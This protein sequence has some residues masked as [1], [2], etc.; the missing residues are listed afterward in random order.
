MFSRESECKN[1]GAADWHSRHS[2]APDLISAQRLSVNNLADAQPENHLVLTRR[3]PRRISPSSTIESGKMIPTIADLA[4]ASARTFTQVVA[5]ADTSSDELAV[6][7]G[8][9][10]AGFRVGATVVAT[11]TLGA[12][13][14][15]SGTDGSGATTRDTAFAGGVEG[16]AGDGTT[17]TEA[18]RG[19]GAGRIIITL[20]AGEAGVLAGSSCHPPQPTAIVSTAP[21]TAFPVHRG[22]GARATAGHQRQP[23]REAG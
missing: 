22:I 11:A 6:R 3:Q 20:G 21:P 12:G 7:I 15:N 16:I 5:L 13:F 17:A 18:R 14:A 23:S 8:L 2:S 1:S 19:T 4:F 10:S 9:V